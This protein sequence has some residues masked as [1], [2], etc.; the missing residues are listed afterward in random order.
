MN[1]KQRMNLQEVTE[2]IQ[3]NKVFKAAL[4]IGVAVLTLYLLGKAC[5][6][7]AETIRGF[8][9]LKAAMNGN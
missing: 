4:Y 3:S 2:T 1:E 8:N 6:G 7:L 9:D 5:K